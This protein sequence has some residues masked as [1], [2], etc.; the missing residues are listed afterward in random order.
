[1]LQ[2]KRLRPDWNVKTYVVPISRLDTNEEFWAE[3]RKLKDA[4]N[5]AVAT[6]RSW[7]TQALALQEKLVQLNKAKLDVDAVKTELKTLGGDR[8]TKT[9]EILKTYSSKLFTNDLESLYIAA[10]SAMD[11]AFRK[12]GTLHFKTG[13][14]S[15]NFTKRFKSGG[16]AFDDLFTDLAPESQSLRRKPLIFRAAPRRESR[17]SQNKTLLHC[18]YLVGKSRIPIEFTGL[19]SYPAFEGKVFVKRAILVGKWS[20]AR[21]WRWRLILNIEEPPVKI[22]PAAPL[23]PSAAID[24]GYRRFAEYIRYGF[25]VD[26]GGNKFELRLPTGNMISAYLKNT[27]RFLQ[28]KVLKNPISRISTTM[29]PGTPKRVQISSRRKTR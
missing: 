7:D 17:R 19:W 25:V 20:A 9:R 26:T 11:L 24:L 27:I 1:M 14:L 10:E 29:L 16:A 23:S 22:P 8:K 21:V 28:K 6:Y 12:G 18:R 4:W 15:V 5:E 2:V 3:A 13:I